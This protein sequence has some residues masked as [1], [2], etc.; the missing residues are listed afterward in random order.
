MHMICLLMLMVMHKSVPLGG[1]ISISDTNV[2]FYT[3][4][5]SVRQHA[6]DAV[7]APSGRHVCGERRTGDVRSTT[8]IARPDRGCEQKQSRH[9]V[10]PTVCRDCLR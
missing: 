3:W 8:W 5:H 7:A 10:P 1:C 4:H 2:H 6:H 9:A